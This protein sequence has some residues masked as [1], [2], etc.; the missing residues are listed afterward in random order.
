MTTQGTGWA[1]VVSLLTVNGIATTGMRVSAIAIPWFILTTTGSVAQTGLVVAFELTPYVLAKALAGPV[2]DRLGQRRVSMV[3]D[4]LSAV[5]IAAIPVA[6][7]LGGLSIGVLLALVAIGGAVRGPGDNAKHTM[8]P[9]VAERAGVP[10]ERVTGPFGAVE[11]G[12]GLVGPAIAAVLIAA[13]GPP[14]AIGVTAACFALS[15]LIVLVGLPGDLDAHHVRPTAAI[16]VRGYG[17]ELAEGFV[18]L[19]NDRLRV[20]LVVMILITNLLDM[21]KTAVLL[22]VWADGGGHGVAA[23]SLLLTCFAMTSVVSSLL[24]GWLGPRLPR[25]PTY[26]VAFLIA[27]PPPFLAL[28]LDLPVVWVAVIYAIS[29]FASGFL[30]PML[31]AMLFERIPRPLLG[32]VTGVVDA[33]AWSGMPFGGLIAA[34]LIAVSGLGTTFLI[35]AGLY[36]IA[37]LIPLLGSRQSFD[38]PAVE[39]E[40]ATTGRTESLPADLTTQG[41][42]GG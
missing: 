33:I 41:R 15:A 27:G 21:A 29:G 23:I 28:G 31:G 16:T 4:L 12:S 24:A 6:H 1:P 19:K 34:A 17:A 30:N 40:A 26:F 20:T 14:A 7:V 32:R 8:V 18:F 38:P 5:A 10:L 35:C 13:A 42:S 36:L 3:A 11:R 2:I 39:T 22:P 37:T 9:L 25:R